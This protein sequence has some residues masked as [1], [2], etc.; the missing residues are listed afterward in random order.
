MVAGMNEGVHISARVQ[1][2]CVSVGGGMEGE[3]ESCHHHVAVTHLLYWCVKAIIIQVAEESVIH[4]PTFI[5][6]A[7]KI[8]GGFIPLRTHPYNLREV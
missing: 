3:G 5:P 2:V 4:P 7:R 8:S 1:D 6:A